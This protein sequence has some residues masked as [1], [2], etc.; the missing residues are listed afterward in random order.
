MPGFTRACSAPTKD[1]PEGVN[2][3]ANRQGDDWVSLG[4]GWSWPVN[5]RILYNRCAADPQ[6]RPWAK[7]ARLAAS[8]LSSAGPAR[9]L[10]GYVY[11][12]AAGKNWVG[13]D[14]P[15]FPV[16]KPPSTP[17]KTD[18][19]G[20]ETHDGASP[21]IMKAD[22]KGWL[23][24]PNGLL[25][26]PLPTHYEPYES[27]VPNIVYPKQLNNPVMLT[28]NIKENPHAA[29]G[30]RDYPHVITTYRLTEHHTTGAMSRWLPWLAELQP[31][32]F[33]ETIPGTCRGTRYPQHG[34][35]GDFD[36]ARLDP[37][38]GAGDAPSAPV[39]VERP[40][41]ASSRSADALGLRWPRQG[42]HR[43]RPLRAGGRSECNHS[44]GQSIPVPGA[45]GLKACL[46]GSLSCG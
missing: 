34:L 12:D 40:N 43:Q 42:R 7:E 26:G 39:A 17:A 13:L 2:R 29:V 32:M 24:A 36:A 5:R 35:G 16:T 6:G 1:H 27:P 21:F 10:R 37:C 38:Q 15:D 23:F 20:I 4:W 30:S 25:D 33:A 14:V 28:W 44:R 18:G 3:A 46:M 41:G 31:E 19:V 22:G 8:S 9:W 45:E 11:W